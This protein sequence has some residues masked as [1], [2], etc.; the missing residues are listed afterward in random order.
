MATG[1]REQLFSVFTQVLPADPEDAING[2]ELIERIKPLLRKPY[3]DNTLRQHFSVLAA[4]PTSPIARVEQGHGYYLRAVTPQVTPP[5]TTK[6]PKLT[7]VEDSPAVA[8]QKRIVQLEEK[9]RAIFLRYTE[10][11]NQFPV[12]IEHTR[13]T[14]RPAGV[15]KWKFPDVVALEWEVGQVSDT[16]FSLARDLLEVKKSLGE[17]P[18]KLISVE[19]KVELTLGS[20]RENFFQC[21]SNSKWAHAAQLAVAG[22][23]ADKTLAEELRRLGTSYDVTVVSYN[24]DLGYLDSLPPADMIAAMNDKDFDSIANNI[25]ITQ[26]ASGKGRENLDWEHIRDLRVQSDEFNS[27]FEWIAYCLEKKTPYRFKDFSQIAKL[28]GR[29]LHRR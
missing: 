26:V 21:V 15:N 19:L 17:P 8:E 5:P 16:G 6:Q 25:T 3:S 22:K 1:L 29:Y 4:D 23:I 11:N 7:V 24:L 2:T 14:K 10:Q 27:L 12:H 9:F 20:F 18:F 13:G 28:E